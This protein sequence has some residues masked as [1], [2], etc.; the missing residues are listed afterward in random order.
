MQ[1]LIKISHMVQELGPVSLF[2]NDDLGKASTKTNGIWQ[3]VQ[4]GLININVYTKFYP[5]IP[6]SSRVMGNFH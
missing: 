3:S 2:Q 1:D 6:Y 4:L 5:N